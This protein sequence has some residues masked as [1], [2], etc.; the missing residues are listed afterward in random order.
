MG[1][2][3]LAARGCCQTVYLAGGYQKCRCH[4]LHVVA[5]RWRCSWS[6]PWDG[7]LSLAL[8]EGHCMHLRV[9][10]RS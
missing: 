1:S 3:T 9:A 5:I 7:R 10:M 6:S 8:S 4:R 2:Q